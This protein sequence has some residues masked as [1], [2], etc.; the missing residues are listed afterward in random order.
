MTIDVTGS[1][2][3]GA[4]STPPQTDGAT[5][6]PP[7]PADRRVRLAVTGMT[8]TACAARLER[9]LGKV[10]GVRASV[11]YATGT[12]T[13]DA[14]AEV[15]DQRLLD[16][17]AATGYG[18]TVAAPGAVDQR[19]VADRRH[20]KSL[21]RRLLVALV[22]FF[23]VADLSLVVALVPGARFPGWQWVLLGLSLPI[24]TWCAWPF[25]RAALKNGAR[26]T[27]TMDTLVSLGVAVAAVWSLVTAF[28]MDPNVPVPNGFWGALTHSGSIYMETAAGITVFVLAGRYLEAWARARAG[29]AVRRLS[30]LATREVRVLLPNGQLMEI[31]SREVKQGQRFVCLPGERVGT[32][33]VVRDGTAGVDTSAMTGEH[34][35][36][37]LRPGDDI[38]GGS[39]VVDGRLVIEATAVGSD[40]RLAAMIDLVEQGQA[41]KSAT[42]RMVDR[43]SAVFVPV[44]LVIAAATLAGWLIAGEPFSCGM[45]A[46]LGVL[47]IA[48][49]CAL[50]LATPVALLAAAGRGAVSGLFVRGQDSL[51]T[52]RQVDTV[53]LDKTGTVTSGRLTV[54]GQA[55]TADAPGDWLLLAAAAESGS[56]HSIAAAVLAATA[57]QHPDAE[58]AAATEFR[59][60]A[61]RG[62]SAVVDGH[63]VLVGSP[64]SMGTRLPDELLEALTRYQ[65][66]GLTTSTVSVDGRV[67]GL[68]ALQDS[69][70]DSAAPTVAAL[71]E[72]G[73]QVLLVT[74]DHRRAAERVAKAI[75]ITDVHAGVGPEQKVQL[76][77]ELQAAGRTVAMV[78]DGINDAPA[79]AAADLGVAI[80]T[81]TDVAID[82]ADVV[83]LRDDLNGVVDTLV[84]SDRTVA[85]IRQNLWW[86]F[87]Y[88][89][90]AVP[91]AVAGF[92][93]PLLASAAMALSSFLVVFNSLRLRKLPLP[94]DS[95]P[96]RPGVPAAPSVPA[97]PAPV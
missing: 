62:I 29:D 70:L 76:I 66:R 77:G 97:A 86:A 54:V 15:P 90:A 37:P 26:L 65:E 20:A 17:V 81:G 46:A 35:P 63:Q 25:H 60:V 1:T 33:G 71:Q 4:G 49:P 23:P 87:G 41:R 8:C 95:S 24:V 67:C 42:Q 7:P 89:V 27:G 19:S 91:V 82:A 69:V 43:V 93:N 74:G 18:A 31:P 44:I 57:E 13:L 56:E 9:K 59:T 45:T 51:E 61:G 48:C 73:V 32:D 2:P 50:G 64:G 22:L 5:S 96:A 92:A 75:G 47:V 52:G 40:T 6:D 94:S 11:N 80:G 84:L 21:L 85:T 55:E 72:Q 16:T 36:R 10:P 30:E 34:V 83:L 38:T 14:P 28:T 78:G 79:L 3:T 68:L 12:A 58:L 88:N 53:V 39:L